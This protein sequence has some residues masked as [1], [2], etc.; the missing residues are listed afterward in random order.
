MSHVVAAQQG[1]G[2][3]TLW[4]IMVLTWRHPWMVIITILSCF[5]SSA[6]QLA[7]PVLLGQAVD[8]AE[9]VLDGG[10]GAI[11]ALWTIAIVLLVV[12]ILR[13]LFTMS[14]NYFGEA[15]GHHTA[16]ELRLAVYEKIQRLSFSYHDKVHTGDL[17]TVGMLDL[18]GVRMFF[19]TGLLRV[20]LLGTLIGVGAYML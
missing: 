19:A 13:G 15:V 10:V 8:R 14:M 16:Y 2:L 17:I 5:I 3:T 20:V 11:D 7:T 18:E 6:L 4:R 9:G 12:S 1:K